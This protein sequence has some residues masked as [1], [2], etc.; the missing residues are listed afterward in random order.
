[1]SSLVFVYGTL[2][3]GQSRES[4]LINQRYIG[5]AKTTENYALFDLGSFPAL[6]HARPNLA[7]ARKIYGELY[8]VQDDC[9]AKLDQIEGVDFNLYSREIITLEEINLV[10]LPIHNDNFRLLHSKKAE[11]YIYLQDTSK[12]RECGFFWS[13]R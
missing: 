11:A 6:V 5:I 12:H 7:A 2:K 4:V 3:S 9:I 10:N 13:S 1:M 8:E